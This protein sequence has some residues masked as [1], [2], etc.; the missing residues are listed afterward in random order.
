MSAFQHILFPVDFSKR[1]RVVRPFAQSLAAKFQAKLTL[2]HIVQ[3]PTG[4]Y[5]GI[6]GGYP[7][8]FDV[9]AMEEAGMNELT[10]FCEESGLTGEKIVK[11]GD[12]ATEI[13][14]FVEQNHVD[15]VMLPTHGYGKFRQL[16]LGSVTAKL[17]HDVRCPIWTATHTDDP[18][19][20]EHIECT[21][22]IGA[23]DIGPESVELIQRYL[24]LARDFKAK[25]RLVHAVPA[26]ANDAQAGLDQSFLRYLLQSAREEIGRLQE[27]AATDLELCI[28]G[29]AVSQVVRDAALHHNADMVLMGRGALHE[30]FGQLRS[31]AYAIIRDAP[32][33]V[34]SV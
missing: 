26:A 4:W 16:L 7:I 28:G 11:F 8:L 31:N 21:S 19:L 10:A 1:C 32:C 14:Q 20:P 18:A 25:L 34:L 15:L 29:G 33:P 3:I 9:P 13:E 23:I 12:P 30:R 17:L 24:G 2:M 6:E 22:I 5:G 27:D